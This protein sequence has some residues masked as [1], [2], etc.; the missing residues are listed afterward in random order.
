M[1]SICDPVGSF[2]KEGLIKD[3]RDLNIASLYQR[4]QLSMVQ[5]AK[6][7]ENPEKSGAILKLSESLEDIYEDI[8]MIEPSIQVV[9]S[10]DEES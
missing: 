3:N 8:T 6:L 10:I 5:M 4:I 2:I 9:G 1:R 7:I